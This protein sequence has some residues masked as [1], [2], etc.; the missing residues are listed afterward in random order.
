MNVIAFYQNAAK[1]LVASVLDEE[2][3]E[4]L[5]LVGAT[6]VGLEGGD[7]LAL[8]GEAFVE[9]NLVLDVVGGREGELLGGGVGSLGDVLADTSRGMSPVGPL[10]VAD[11]VVVAVPEDTLSALD[12]SVGR[13]VGDGVGAGQNGAG[14][15]REDGRE[16]HCC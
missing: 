1:L 2:R 16:L 11:D 12:G 10:G 13:G 6:L 7:L 14:G 3:A 5:L 4:V 15:D 8:A 9:D